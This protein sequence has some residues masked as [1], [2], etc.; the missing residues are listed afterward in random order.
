MQWVWSWEWVGALTALT[1]GDLASRVLSQ[2]YS[3]SEFISHCF[4]V[5]RIKMEGHM[6]GST[7]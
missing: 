3:F 7:S 5:F 6:G 1:V 2:D 4:W